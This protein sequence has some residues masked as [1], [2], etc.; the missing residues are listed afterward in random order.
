MKKSDSDEMSILDYMI[1]STANNHFNDSPILAE[2]QDELD[3]WSIV[4]SRDNLDKWIDSSRD[5][6]FPPDLYSDNIGY[7]IE[8]FRVDDI[9]FENKQGKSVNTEKRAE[10]IL[11]K[12]MSPFLNNG[13][14]LIITKGS[15][16][17]LSKEQLGNFAKIAKKS[18]IVLFE[19]G[20]NNIPSKDHHNY[21]R[22]VSNFNRVV[23]KH[24]D[25]IPMYRKNH[26][27]LKLVFLIMDESTHY[28][29][30]KNEVRGIKEGEEF[31]LNSQDIHFPFLDRDMMTLFLEADIDY[32]V[33]YMPYK[34]FF[35]ISCE[36]NNIFPK[37]AVID[38]RQYEDRIKQL[39][40]YSKNNM[41]SNEE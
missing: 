17:P 21:Q 5:T 12:Q 30:A 41:Q 23:K 8:V 27:N 4:S 25:S 34:F 35:P 29:D 22:Y 24:I 20:G 18:D 14:K 31:E 33:W 10:G 39:R 13:Q 9:A 32:I 37:V 36:I 28:Y 3:V 38:P 19:D 1:T 26:P 40:D 6:S 2:T 7:M 11:R 16:K 15:G